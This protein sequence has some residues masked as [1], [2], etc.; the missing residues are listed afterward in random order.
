MNLIETR[1]PCLRCRRALPI[2]GRL[3]VGEI[4][5]C[6]ACNTPHEV[7]D[8]APLEIGPSIPIEEQEED[9]ADWTKAG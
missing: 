4:V 1:I 3:L 5:H 9:F 7:F 2:E 6:P 8:L